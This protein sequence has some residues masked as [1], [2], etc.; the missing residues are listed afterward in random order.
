LVRIDFP[1]KLLYEIKSNCLFI[2]SSK[3]RKKKIDGMKSK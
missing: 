1:L 2:C 3:N